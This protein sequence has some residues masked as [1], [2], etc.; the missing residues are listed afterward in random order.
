MRRILAGLLDGLPEKLR[1][2][3]EQL[4]ASDHEIEEREVK[5]EVRDVIHEHERASLEDSIRRLIRSLHGAPRSRRKVAARGSVDAARTMRANLRYDGVPFRPITVAKVED[6]PSLLI[7]ADVSLSVRAAARFTLQLVHG[8]QS[9]V[10]HVRSF[11]FVSDLVEITSTCSPN[12]RSRRR[13]PGGQWPVQ[14]RCPRHL[15][16]PRLRCRAGEVPGGIRRR[17]QPAYH[18]D[19][20]R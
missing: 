12:I 6:R 1:D 14:R 20:S 11:A 8:L 17:G 13:C 2:H 4:M 19:R 9:M 10:S 7:L 18:R 15:P 3:L 5:A 16:T